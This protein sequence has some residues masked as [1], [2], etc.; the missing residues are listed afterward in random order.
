MRSWLPISAIVDRD[1]R[2]RRLIIIDD[3]N[4]E[5]HWNRC[6]MGLRREALSL[7][8]AFRVSTVPPDRTAPQRLA[9]RMCG[10][11]LKSSSAQILHRCRARETLLLGNWP[12]V[13]STVCLSPR[14]QSHPHLSPFM[15][16]LVIGLL[17]DHRPI[18][19]DF[20]LAKFS[21]IYCRVRPYFG[22][23][24]IANSEKQDRHVIKRECVVQC[25]VFP[26]K[27]N[28]GVVLTKTYRTGRL[29]NG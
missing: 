21:Q 24:D 11:A 5:Q 4:P 16:R 27:C 25:A 6:V 18:M 22:R 17:M 8:L 14:V 26:I 3:V 15:L 7:T 12:I 23:N 19:S 1:F 28:R 29:S 2:E 10:G 9:R 13:C 20:E